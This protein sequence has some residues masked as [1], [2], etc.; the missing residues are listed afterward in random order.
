MFP[1][2]EPAVSRIKWAPVIGQAAEIVWSYDT[3]VTLRQLFYRL[4]SRQLVPNT[5]GA[6]KRL[7][8][9][10]AQARRDG[11]FPRLIDR[12]RSIHRRLHFDSPAGALERLTRSYRL[13]RT[14]GQNVSLYLAA[15]KAGIVSQL[16]AWFGGLGIPV[17]ALGGYAS[18]TYA[19]RVAADV[20]RQG[21]PSVLLYAGDFDPSGEDIDRDFIE[22]SGCWCKVV[23]VVLSA[24]QVHIYR[25]PVNPGKVTDSRAAAF[26]ERHGALMQVELDAL[27]PTDLRALFRAAI[28]G[29][30]DVPLR[31]DAPRGAAWPRAA[32]TAAGPAG[33][34]CPVSL[35]IGPRWARTP[36]H[37]AG[38]RLRS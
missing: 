29:Y 12:G 10:T 9:L 35:W 37:K 33:R 3:E 34:G 8:E 14:R 4:V 23:R 17:L 13:G 2:E 7:S 27:D 31:G 21:R 28:D 5:D 36:P 11:W 20:A 1:G 24:S 22:R 19:D 6:Y 15:E 18:Q 30:W 38:R 26:T 32:G 25:L 16:Q